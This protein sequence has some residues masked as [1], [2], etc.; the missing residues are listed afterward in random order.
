MLH[1]NSN[2]AIV[3][4]FVRNCDGNFDEDRATRAIS[5]ARLILRKTSRFDVDVSSRRFAGSVG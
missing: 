5:G 2:L 1:D 4:V 3:I